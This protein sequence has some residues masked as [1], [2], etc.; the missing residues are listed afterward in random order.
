MGDDAK[1]A[2][3]G[4]VYIC[5]RQHS[6]NTVLALALGRLPP[7]L[8]LPQ[9][10]PYFEHLELIDQTRNPRKRVAYAIRCMML[11]LESARL[12]LEVSA[13]LNRW[14]LDHSAASAIDIYLEAMHFAVRSRRK[15]WWAQKAT[16]YIFYADQVLDLVPNSR[17]IYMLRNPYDLAASKKQRDPGIDR[18]WAH[19]VSWYKGLRKALAL[20]ER[21]PARFRIVRYEDL[22]LAPETTMRTLCNFLG[23]AF[24]PQCLDVPHIN[25]AEKP[26]VWTVDADATY[27]LSRSRVFYY[28]SHLAQPEMAALDQL[29]SR[30]LLHEFYPNLPHQT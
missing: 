15:E 19:S 18:I 13:W 24:D 29:S 16:S 25:R 2:V 6:G 21:H 4:P 17:M 11:E 30:R 20:Q 12:Q 23:V 3:P 26:H 5:G 7:F 1:N 28:P 27:G 9:D 8:A 14:I 22:V 10:L